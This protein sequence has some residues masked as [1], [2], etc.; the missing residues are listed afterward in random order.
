MEFS[1]FGIKI[2]INRE[3]VIIVVLIAIV[4]I[5]F[6]V[7]RHFSGGDD[8]I[9]KASAN[10]DGKA[11]IDI[12]ASGAAPSEPENRDEIQVYVVGCVKNP[13]IVTLERGQIIRDAIEAA[14]GATEDA[15]IEN[16][17]LAY[18]LNSNVMLRIKAVGENASTDGVYSSVGSGAEIIEDSGGA[19]EGIN[20]GSGKININQ[21]SV[22]E[23][24][25]LPGIGEVTAR[26][27]VHYRETV[28]YFEKIEDIM[29]V[30]GIKEGRFESIRELITVE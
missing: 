28:G 17:N 18:K 25:Q 23:L 12:K 29:K 8:L 16:V 27:I 14:G 3:Y 30:R 1:L 4:V 6:A 26:D 24:Q 13:G 11:N 21:A 10:A 22:Q 5:G 19:V 15:D 7:Y 2:K 9:I 20:Q